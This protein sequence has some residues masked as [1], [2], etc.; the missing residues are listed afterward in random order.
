ML[1]LIKM[2]RIYKSRTKTKNYT[3]IIIK[4][5]QVLIVS[6]GMAD[7][8]RNNVNVCVLQSLKF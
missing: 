5:R 2:C 6:F 8:K 4:I 7:R 3:S 1:T